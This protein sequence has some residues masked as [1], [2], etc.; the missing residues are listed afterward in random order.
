MFGIRADSVLGHFTI[1]TYILGNSDLIKFWI[2]LLPM[3]LFM[4]EGYRNKI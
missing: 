4:G 3:F 1:Y 2:F